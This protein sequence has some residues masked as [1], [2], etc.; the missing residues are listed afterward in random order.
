MALENDLNSSLA[1]KIFQEFVTHVN[2]KAS[3]NA[4]SKEFAMIA[5]ETYHKIMDLLG[6]KL[7]DIS[8]DD[9]QLVS[10][11]IARRDHLRAKQKYRESDDI[12]ATLLEKYSVELMDRAEGS[13]WKKIEK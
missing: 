4:V 9:A 13:F 3:S 1:L 6:L 11:M 8:D 10:A 2:R 5:G 12:R 7:A